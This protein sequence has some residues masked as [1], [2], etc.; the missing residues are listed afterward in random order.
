MQ[1]ENINAIEELCLLGY[2]AMYYDESEPTFTRNVTLPSSGSNNSPSLM[3]DSHWF[4][5]LIYSS[6]L[7]AIHSSETPVEFNW[8]TRCYAAESRELCPG[9]AQSVQPLGYWLDDQGIGVRK[10]ADFS[11]LSRRP[12]LVPGPTQPAMQ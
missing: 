9:I 12:D 7:K 1:H 6:A 4:S 8:S 11:A 2:N 10:E 3:P 5:G